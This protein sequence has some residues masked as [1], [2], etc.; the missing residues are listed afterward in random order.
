LSAWRDAWKAMQEQTA[1]ADL[2]QAILAMKENPC[3]ENENRLKALR[4]MRRNSDG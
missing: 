2:D 4:E 1:Q 3:E